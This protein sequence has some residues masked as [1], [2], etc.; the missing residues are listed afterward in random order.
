M[1]FNGFTMLFSNLL[2]QFIKE[3]VNIKPGVEF[4]VNYTG[5]ELYTYSF[6]NVQ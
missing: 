1:P 3:K 6:G 4:L 5:N 2:F